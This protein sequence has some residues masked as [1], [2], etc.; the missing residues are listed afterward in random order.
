M[1][2]YT[3][4]V[5]SLRRYIQF[6]IILV[7]IGMG[8]SKEKKGENG[9][10][11]KIRINTFPVSTQSK[12][13]LLVKIYL[14]IPH[15]SLQFVKRN[16]EFVA[17]YEAQIVVMNKKGKLKLKQSWNDS[18]HVNNYLETITENKVITLFTDNIFKVDDYVTMATVLDIKSREI[19]KTRRDLS[20]DIPQFPHINKPIILLDKKGDWGFH[21][22]LIPSWNNFLSSGKDSVNIFLSGIGVSEHC[23]LTWSVWNQSDT[24]PI[25]EKKES[26]S[27]Q[28][29]FYHYIQIPLDILTEITT[30]LEVK[31]FDGKNKD[32]KRIQLI[33]LKPGIS[34]HISD[35]D[36]AIEQMKY[37]LT[38][39][40]KNKLNDQKK[41]KKELFFKTLW[42]SR[43]PTPETIE[44]ELMDEYY[45]RVAYTMEH[46]SG[47]QDGWKTDM[48]MIYILFGFPDEVKRY[49]D[50]GNQKSYELWY[51]FNVQKSFRFVD[52]NGFGDYQLESPHFLSVP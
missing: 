28:N 8:L 46:F 40:E 37:I 36:D 43:D 19:H 1:T 27:I 48:G 32:S 39:E 21:P 17:G 34:N 22:N 11:K 35:I 42:D 9:N 31:I 6:S 41:S 50:Y 26:L 3:K 14:E 2:N 20:L 49:S 7:I 16:H 5:V 38:S 33:I 18:V 52:S 44:N 13:S 45:K 51:Y 12:D 25:I 4:L 15:K 24:Q 29:Y 30:T 23:E 47:F 10:Y